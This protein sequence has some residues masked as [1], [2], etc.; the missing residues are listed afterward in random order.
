MRIPVKFPITLDDV[1]N[2][3]TAL[4]NTGFAVDTIK[5]PKKVMSRTL[6]LCQEW[7]ILENGDIW[8]F[9]AVFQKDNS[10]QNEVE[11][12]GFSHVVL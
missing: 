5:M 12:L 6:K 3:F 2:W 1:L 4:H 7:T 8:C 11:V 9:G 10:L